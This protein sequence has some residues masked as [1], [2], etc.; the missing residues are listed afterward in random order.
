MCSG[1][2]FGGLGPSSRHFRIVFPGASERVISPAIF[3]RKTLCTVRAHKGPYIRMSKYVSANRERPPEDPTPAKIRE[4]RVGTRRS[5]RR[6]SEL[7]A[8]E[9]PNGQ[10]W[11]H[12]IAPSRLSR[13]CAP[14]RYPLRARWGGEGSKRPGQQT[15]DRCQLRGELIH[16]QGNRE[17]GD[18]R[19]AD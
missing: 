11:T 7:E 13:A 5:T 9:P 2:P 18:E 16:V 10:G 19:R 1:S 4:A 12:A 8:F 3:S 15:L 14:Q 6:T 17:Q